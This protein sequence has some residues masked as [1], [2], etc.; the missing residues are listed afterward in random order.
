MFPQKQILK[1]GLTTASE[2]GL[3]PSK[4]N[5]KYSTDCWQQDWILHYFFPTAHYKLLIHRSTGRILSFWVRSLQVALDAQS[6]LN[7][8]RDL[9]FAVTVQLKFDALHK[10]KLTFPSHGISRSVTVRTGKRLSL[11]FV[12]PFP[13][14]AREVHHFT[15]LQYL[16]GSGGQNLP[17]EAW[18]HS[19]MSQ[20]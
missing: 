13:F 20:T 14:E 10:D 16:G 7:E 19:E 1:Y 2:S 4:V 6:A 18:W 3:A 9:V 12:W 5:C 17:G 11:Y 8:Q 15:G